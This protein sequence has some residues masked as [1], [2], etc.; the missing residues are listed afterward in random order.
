MLH[1]S[2]YDQQF[3]FVQNRNCTQFIL[4]TTNLVLLLK[5]QWKLNEKKEH[6]LCKAQMPEYIR[7]YSAKKTNCAKPSV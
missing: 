3:A 6:I 7:K 1:F 2:F 5:K 4:S